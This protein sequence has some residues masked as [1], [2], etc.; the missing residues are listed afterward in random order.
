MA[1]LMSLSSSRL[2][3]SSRTPRTLMMALSSGRLGNE[4]RFSIVA[5]LRKLAASVA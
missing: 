2:P 5:A 4:G 1:S 3:I